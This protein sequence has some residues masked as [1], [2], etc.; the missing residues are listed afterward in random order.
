MVFKKNY[1]NPKKSILTFVSSQ[2][3]GHPNRS[4]KTEPFV[5][6]DKGM[7]FT[8]YGTTDLVEAWGAAAAVA[9]GVLVQDFFI[10]F[11]LFWMCFVFLIFLLLF[12]IFFDL[13]FFVF[14]G[15]FK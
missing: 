5:F 13:A 1:P 6:P 11:L 9:L 2:W 14:F 15:I 12:L 8:W 10:F 3:Q 7:T 4:M